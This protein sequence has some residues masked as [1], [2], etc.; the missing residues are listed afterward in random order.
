[1]VLPFAEASVADVLAFCAWL[2]IALVHPAVMVLA[3]LHPWTV[4]RLARQRE[5]QPPVSVLL[6]V[7]AADHD[8]AGCLDRVVRL[9]YPR[10]EVLVCSD[11]VDAPAFRLIKDHAQRIE[12]ADLRF[13]VARERIGRNPKINN[14]VPALAASNYET[15]L[16]KDANVAFE[17]GDLARLVRYLGSGTGLVCSIPVGVNP[18]SLA[19]DVEQSMMNGRDAPYTLA[20]SVLGMNLGYGKVMLFRKADL[21]QAGGL[22]ILADHFGDDHALSV[23]MGRLGLATVYTDGFVAQPL[24]NRSWRTVLDRQLRWL[25]I[26]RNQAFPAFF[27]EPFMTWP[28]AV[29]SAWLAAPLLGWT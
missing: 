4:R 8:V 27:L 9:S 20:A 24:E 2:S 11:S 29:A 14:L 6:P 17:V 28:A 15:Q 19:A 12:G 10:F 13:F 1:M 7:S 23:A 16:I 3:L 21:V 18:R 5:D 26:R 25:V 22:G